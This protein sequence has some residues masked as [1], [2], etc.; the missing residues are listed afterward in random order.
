MENS[1][2]GKLNHDYP[3]LIKKMEAKKYI[4]LIPKKK[5][6]TDS[7]ILTKRL[8]YNHIYYIDK[9]N[10]HLYINLNG[11]VLKYDHP[12]LTTYLGWPK[13][14]AL[15]V[16]DSYN[17]SSNILCY[18]IDNICDEIHYRM[19]QPISKDNSQLKRFNTQKDYLHYYNNYMTI[20][21]NYKKSVERLKK[22]TN[23]MQYNYMLIKGQE[24]KFSKIFRERTL[25]LI[26]R[27]R[28]NLSNPKDENMIV[29]DISA[30]LVDSLIYN[31]IFNFLYDKINNFYENEEKNMKKILQENISKYDLNALNVD[32]IY[33]NCKFLNAIKKLD[34]INLYS[35]IFEKVKVLLEV[36]TLI[37]EEAK[38][39]YE[40]GNKGNFIPQGDLLFSFWM[41]VVAHS[42]TKNIITEAK[43]LSFFGVRKNN[44]EDYVLTTFIS[45]VDAI[46]KE[47][48]D[49]KTSF[50]QHIDGSEIIFNY[51]PIN[52]K[53]KK[54]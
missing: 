44:E 3:E 37:T 35:T 21:E 2:E 25:K 49:D 53:E 16:L 7:S 30:E 31:N 48:M 18:E 50:S 26:N 27:I 43:F 46:L 45:A 29:Y 19:G 11:R 10:E 8:Y 1:F 28:D 12:K 54:K 17:S 40:S 42:N 32:K 47:L 33:N 14:M 22:F 24:E 52:T 36:N 5:L 39:Y 15:T 41:Y 38:N 23:E 51:A 34:D 4:L 20:N 13:D 9:Y 6:I